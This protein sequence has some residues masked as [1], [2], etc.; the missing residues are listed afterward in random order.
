MSNASAG[1]PAVYGY[2]AHV[3]YDSETLPVAEKLRETLAANFPVELGR[4]N[5]E[6]VGPHPVPQFQIILKTA[7]LQT[8][9]PLLMLNREGSTF[10]SIR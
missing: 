7:Q 2:H 8:V 4:F 10:S 5:G 3:Y 9:V 6:Q 1:S